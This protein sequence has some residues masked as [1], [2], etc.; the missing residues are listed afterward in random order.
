MFSLIS[1]LIINDL[2]NAGKSSIYACASY[3]QLVKLLLGY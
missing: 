3:H 2:K 1:L